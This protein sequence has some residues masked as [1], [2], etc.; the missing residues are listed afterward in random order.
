[1]AENREVTT[2]EGM[3]FANENNALFFE[4]SAKY[5]QNILDTFLEIAKELPDRAPSLSS[6][7]TLGTS[8]KVHVPEHK[9]SCC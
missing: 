6:N 2:E 3:Q 5:D 7:T 1:M 8:Y 9:S 4:V